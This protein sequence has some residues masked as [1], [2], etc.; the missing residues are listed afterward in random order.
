MCP[1]NPPCPAAASADREA[2][3]VITHAHA[4]GWVMLCNGVLCFEDTG[5]ML[6]DGRIIEPHRPVPALTRASA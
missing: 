1:H 3:T 2:A 4:Q 6:P 5:E